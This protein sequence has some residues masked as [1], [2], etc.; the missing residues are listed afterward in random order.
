MSDQYMGK[1][2]VEDEDLRL[3]CHRANENQ[4]V[5]GG[6]KPATLR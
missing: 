6:S 2:M 3:F 1:K 5:M 4:P